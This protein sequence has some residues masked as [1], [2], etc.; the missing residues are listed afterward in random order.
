[1]EKDAKRPKQEVINHDDLLQLF[2]MQSS[3]VTLR[4][5]GR[6]AGGASAGSSSFFRRAGEDFEVVV[7]IKGPFGPVTGAHV[8]PLLQAIN[9]LTIPEGLLTKTGEAAWCTETGTACFPVRIERSGDLEV[10]AA[11]HFNGKL[12]TIGQKTRVEVAPGAMHFASLDFDKAYAEVGEQVQLVLAGFVVET[13]DAASGSRKWVVKDVFGNHIE[14]PLSEN[15]EADLLDLSF[16]GVWS[17]EGHEWPLNFSKPIVTEDARKKRT[18]ETCM[19][20]DLVVVAELRLML[21]GRH[22]FRIVTGPSSCS[23][24]QELTA[25]IE[26]TPGLPESLRLIGE[27]KPFVLKQIRWRSKIEL[28]NRQS[29][30]ANFSGQEVSVELV[31][32]GRS[33]G[34]SYP[35]QIHSEICESSIQ[36][37]SLSDVKSSPMVLELE[38]FLAETDDA[39]PA[40]TYRLQVKRVTDG[41]ELNCEPNTIHLDLP[42]DPAAWTSQDL[43]QN[44]RLGGLLASKSIEPQP[45]KDEFDAEIDGKVLIQRGEQEGRIMLRDSLFHGREFS[46]RVEKDAESASIQKYAK[47]LFQRHT[48]ACLGKGKYRS[49]VAQ[50]ISESDLNLEPKAF[51]NGGYSEIFRGN[52]R[53]QPV[54][55]KIPLVKNRGLEVCDQTVGMMKEVERELT[56][57]RSNTHPHVVEVIGLMVGPG[58]IGIVMELCDT[59]LAK[60]IKEPA[61]GINWAETVRL[62]MDGTAGLGFIHSRKTTW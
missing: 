7:C 14:M 29:Y 56:V 43:A 2:P 18:Y 40:G 44:L 25:K 6:E 50:S 4:R 20:Y 19:K 45:L 23:A 30:V 38:L 13:T 32:T 36:G 12:G 49:S 39:P 58:R 27:G 51:D 10:S 28:L 21:A 24:G 31:P 54:A 5:G 60:R 3:E 34:P 15:A 46:N 11:V 26:I 57:T 8:L 41:C 47:F 35:L 48:E 17:H 9:L 59:S 42:L 61:V 22:T 62:L 16:Q 1:M 52:Y 53:G 33:S 55:V 37:C